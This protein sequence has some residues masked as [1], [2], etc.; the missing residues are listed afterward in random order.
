MTYTRRWLLPVLGV[1]ATAVTP[2]WAQYGPGNGYHYGPGMMWG[3]SWGGPVFGLL[4]MFIFFGAVVLLVVLAIR[5]V[6][7]L[8]AHHAP[9]P[10]PASRTSALDILKERFARGEIDKDEFEERK[11]HLSD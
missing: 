1:L 5:W 6:A 10:P 8:G 3:G 4:T 2:A 11:R 7:G 9:P